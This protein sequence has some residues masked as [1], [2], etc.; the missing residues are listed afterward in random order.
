MYMH[1][2]GNQSIVQAISCPV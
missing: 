1:K 2:F